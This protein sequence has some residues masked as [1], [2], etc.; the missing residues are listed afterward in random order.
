MGSGKTRR[1]LDTHV[2]VVSHVQRFAILWTLALQAPVS[3]GL[4][5]QE[6]WSGLPLPPPGIF[7]FQGLNP[8]LLR[9]LHWQAG[10][11][12]LSHLGSPNV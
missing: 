5:Q 7:S 1:Y 4:S 6:Y 8:H 11:L 2:C 10:S 3:M 12:A 9:L